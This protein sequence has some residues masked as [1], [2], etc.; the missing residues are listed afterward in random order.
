MGRKNESKIFD[1]LQQRISVE[2]RESLIF[3]REVNKGERSRE[4][5]SWK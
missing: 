5:G 2:E 3:E 4:M 1:A